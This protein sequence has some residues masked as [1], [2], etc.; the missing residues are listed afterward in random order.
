M[1]GYY[2]SAPAYDKWNVCPN[3]GE[4]DYDEWDEFWYAI[5][6]AEDDLS[7]SYGS[8]SYEKAEQMLKDQGYGLLVTYEADTMKR[9]DEIKYDELF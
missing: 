7:T 1:M 5:L 6:E 9:I 2:G 3:C 4:S 8:Y